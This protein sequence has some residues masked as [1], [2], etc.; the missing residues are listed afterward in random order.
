MGRRGRRQSKGTEAARCENETA[1][2]QSVFWTSGQ[3]R[4]KESA[5]GNDEDGENRERKSKR[6]EGFPLVERNTHRFATI[7]RSA[8]VSRKTGVLRNELLLGF[9]IAG[10]RSW[11]NDNACAL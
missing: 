4:R 1:G 9:P 3:R 11:A 2:P 8:R 6:T 10:N 7:Q 5:R